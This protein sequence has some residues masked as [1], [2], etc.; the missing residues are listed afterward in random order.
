MRDMAHCSSSSQVAAK[1]LDDVIPANIFIA[2]TQASSLFLGQFVVLKLRKK[3][4]RL[5]KRN[6]LM[7]T[8]SSL[9]G[10][11]FQESC[12]KNANS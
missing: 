6:Q 9:S 3:S 4:H 8:G 7:E 12:R 1:L 5:A 11:A 2:P 10:I